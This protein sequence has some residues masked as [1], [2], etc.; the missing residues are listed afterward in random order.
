MHESQGSVQTENSRV[1]S[2]RLI[3]EREQSR[4]VTC[5]EASD[6]GESLIVFFE[7]LNADLTVASDY[8]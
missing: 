1:E 6:I 2:L 3:L 8:E 4:L 5:D 7:T